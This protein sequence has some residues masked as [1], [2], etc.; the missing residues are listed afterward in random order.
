M[1]SSA[2]ALPTRY[3]RKGSKL[4]GWQREYPDYD[5]Q[6]L[7]FLFD[8]VYTGTTVT[9]LKW[10]EEPGAVTAEEL[11]RRL[12]ILGYHALKAAKTFR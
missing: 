12:E 11:A 4:E 6:K 10:I 9:M 8:Y 7:D 1:A 3:S 5:R 2:M